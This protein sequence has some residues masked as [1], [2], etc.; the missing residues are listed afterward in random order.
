VTAPARE[1]TCIDCGGRAHLIS[2][3]PED[4]RW[5]AGDVVVYRCADCHD[6]WDVVLEEEDL[7]E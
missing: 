5:E 1:I 6:R 3:E 2:Y 7:A 4:G